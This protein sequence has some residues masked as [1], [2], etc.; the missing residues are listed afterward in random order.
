MSV[1]IFDPVTK[2]NKLL[3][4]IMFRISTI[5]GVFFLLVKN[6]KNPP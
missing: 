6:E 3:L 1:V 5:R 2:T 4:P